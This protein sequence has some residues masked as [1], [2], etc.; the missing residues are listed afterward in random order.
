MFLGQVDGETLQDFTGIATESA[1]ERAVTIHDNETELLVRLQ[2]LTQGFGVEFVV[3]KVKR[4]VYGLERLK[5]NVNLPLL[6]FRGDDF[7][8]VDD[9]SIRGNF[10]VQFETLLSGGNGRQNGKSVHARLD[11]GGS[12]LW[13]T[14]SRQ[15]ETK[16][17]GERRT[18]RIL[19]PT[20]LPLA[21]FDPS[22]LHEKKVIGGT[23]FTGQ[24]G[25]RGR[26]DDERNHGSSISAGGFQALDE[27]LHLPNLDVLLGI[28][29][30]LLLLLGAHVGRGEGDV[31]P[32]KKSEGFCL[33]TPNRGQKM[34]RPE[35]TKTSDGVFSSHLHD[36]YQ[37]LETRSPRVQRQPHR[38]GEK[39]MGHTLLIDVESDGKFPQAPWGRGVGGL[40]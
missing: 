38:K 21:K 11:V 20:S 28:I 22:A 12:T 35:K 36:L 26:T 10:V 30:L 24:S 6:S 40:R 31:Q 19:Q 4:S 39:G 27:L 5:V 9:Q 16:K 33:T 1:E 34:G 8:T 23:G 7:T 17:K 15:S 14:V 32:G 18:V 37:P 13:L 25:A 29:R 2:Q 3:A